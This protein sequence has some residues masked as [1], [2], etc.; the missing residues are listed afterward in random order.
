[1]L[2]A[3]RRKLGWRFGSR[4]CSVP[5][6]AVNVPAHP[7]ASRTLGSLQWCSGTCSHHMR[8]HSGA[9]SVVNERKKAIGE[10]HSEH[11]AYL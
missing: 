8:G 11:S 7:S 3:R 10:S 9:R 4:A 2:D 5:S 6:Y 1:M